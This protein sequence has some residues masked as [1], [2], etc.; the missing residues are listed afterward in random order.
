MVFDKKKLRE[1][2]AENEVKM[3]EDLQIFVREMMK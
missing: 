3:I 2:L 1:I